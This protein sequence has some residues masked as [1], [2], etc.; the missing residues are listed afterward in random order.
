MS[1]VGF[2]ARNHPQQVASRGPRPGVDD[3]QTSPE[4]FMPLRERFGFTVDACAL[5]HNAKCERFW[6]PEEDGLARSWAGERVWCNPPYSSIE[7]W[8]AKAWA[9]PA[10]LVVM[11]V[12]ANRTE[13]G[14]WQRRVEP[15]RDRGG[16]LAVEFLAGRLRFIAHDATEIRP[17]ER[18]RF[19]C[20]LLIWGPADA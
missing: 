16:R 18:P 20:A 3:R 17:N 10:E 7:P 13:Q 15:R 6:T 1:L 14:W 8:V 4:V 2:G 19:G 11:L 9:E 5:P 12:P